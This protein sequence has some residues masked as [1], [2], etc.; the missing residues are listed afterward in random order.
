M[1]ILE[2]YS[3]LVVKIDMIK[4]QIKLNEWELEYWFGIKLD[5]TGIPLG[6]KGSMRYGALTSVIQADKKIDAINELRGQLEFYEKTRA[7][8]EELFNSVEDLDFKIAK[9]RIVE[10]MTHQEVADEL[11]YSHQYIRRRWMNLKRNTQATD[12]LET[13]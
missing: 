13:V 6:G 11:G 2:S 4:E 1:N 5:G 7:R 8:M 12:T 3:D 9:L 10:G